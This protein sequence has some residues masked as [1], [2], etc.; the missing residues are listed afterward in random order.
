MRRSF[1]G[2]C[3]TPVTCT[4]GSATR[5][6]A[7]RMALACALALLCDGAWPASAHEGHGGI[8]PVRREM[9][10]GAERW[11]IALGVAPADPVVGEE[12]R[13]EVKA[14]ELSGEVGL[15]ARPVSGDRVRVV[16]DG[17]NVGLRVAQ[18]PGVSAA[19]YQAGAAGQ[20][21]LVVEIRSG[22]VT[23][24]E[25]FSVTVH[26]GPVQRLRPFV[27]AA[28]LLASVL[29]VAMMWRRRRPV[30]VS[31]SRLPLAWI[32]GA[33]ISV[34]A[35]VLIGSFAIT[36]I[37][38]ERLLPGRQPPAIDWIADARTAIEGIPDVSETT[39][40]PASTDAFDATAMISG[41][42]VASPDRVT[43]V[44]VPMAGRVLPL[45]HDHVGVG[46]R[47]AKGQ[48]L[49]LLQP[50][51]IMH[52]ALHLINQ[53]WPI[54]QSMS[55]AK[56]R[57][58]EADMTAARLKLAQTDQAV[59]LNEVQA[60]EAAAA[61]AKSEFERWNRTLEMHDHQ[62]TDDQPTRIDLTAPIGGEI[63]AANFTQGQ[64]VYEG[65]LLFTVVDLNVVWVEAR[66]PERWV[67]RFRGRTADFMTSAYPSLTFTGRL[68]RV[69]AQIDPD[70]RTLS[71]FYAVDNPSKR[72]RIGMLVNVP[73]PADASGA[74][75]TA[76]LSARHDPA[77]SP[78]PSANNVPPAT[79]TNGGVVPTSG[80]AANRQMRTV[81]GRVRPK[82]ELIA[83]VVS[84]IWGRM[85]FAEKPLSIGEVVHKG[86]PLVRLIL[87]LSADERYAMEARHV[88]LTSA[89][90]VAQAR[91]R[92]RELEY[93]RAIALLKSEPTNRFRQQ[94]VESLERLFKAASEE[95]VLFERQERA[96]QTV[97]QRR[98]PRITIVE[99]PISGVITELDVKP[100]QLNPTGEFRKLCTIVDLSRVWIEA[101]VYEGDIGSV[102]DG[103]DAAYA[104]ADSTVRQ[105]LSRP[106]AVLPSI[107]EKTRTGKVIYELANPD[108][109]LRLGMA[110]HILYAASGQA[111]A[112][113]RHGSGF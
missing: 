36:P 96:F 37:L 101:D 67:S 44:T 13:I 100:G 54:L 108:G 15:I 33:G 34:I 84:P 38:A 40:L 41:R 30:A 22:G 4:K 80:D 62:I 95:Q 109:R 104:L 90:E 49:A 85:E 19:S 89:V 6:L 48:K 29:G 79:S 51:Y 45:E 63:A 75:A 74:P 86:Q 93:R 56:L 31:D 42:V 9:R 57:M 61:A 46:Q 55:G 65:D 68:Q 17:T 98:D 99:A 53:R 12:L 5:I 107:D 97:R 103:T 26:P 82:P 28:F 106:V 91:Q 66:V 7:I 94:Q 1:A 113:K 21:Q 16:V 59:S 72:L 111:N 70:T 87:Q 83:Q 3:E 8:A 39:L 24:R 23:G 14:T 60:A 18:T 20:H 112:G 92:Q 64:L 69:A 2:S 73:L 78:S 52:D 47:V 105:P 77:A 102:L 76:P 81:L 27:V 10:V 88:E 71:H 58:L 43:D 50:T 35:I 25:T 32:A 11:L 110:V